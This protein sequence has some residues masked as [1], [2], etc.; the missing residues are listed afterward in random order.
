MKSHFTQIHNHLVPLP[1][2]HWRS[3]ESVAVTNRGTTV[4]VGVGEATTTA[5][6]WSGQQQ[7]CLHGQP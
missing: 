5:N 7:R 4:V 2:M 6:I 1:F 3:C